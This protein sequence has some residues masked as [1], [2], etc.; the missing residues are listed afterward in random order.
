MPVDTMIGEEVEDFYTKLR[1]KI[2]NG[3]VDEAVMMVNGL[4]STQEK[5]GALQYLTITVFD[6][7]DRDSVLDRARALD[8]DS[9]LALALDSALDRKRA[10]AL[11]HALDLAL[12]FALAFA[13]DSARALASDRDH[14][15]AL[16]SGRALA[17]ARARV[18]LYASTIIRCLEGLVPKQL[19]SGDEYTEDEIQLAGHDPLTPITLVSQVAP[20][21]QALI[22][23]Q[24]VII[25][26][27]GEPFIE[28]RIRSISE[29][30]PLSFQ[31]DG[32]ADAIR[33][34]REIV[35]PW[36][37]KHAQ[38]M[39]ELE[40][41]EKQV[42][43]GKAEVDIQETR[44]RTA[45]TRAATKAAEKRQSAEIEQLLLENEAKRLQNEEK[46]LE[47]HREKLDLAL[48]IVERFAPDLSEKERLLAVTQMMES[49]TTLTESPLELLLPGTTSED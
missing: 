19:V 46:R 3:E 40:V 22:D 33:V 5:I 17:L 24:E 16:D 29:H 21:L 48:S 23:L 8:L 30:S 36:R 35:T 31:M 45:Q 26:L 2:E 32:V 47:I 18:Q 34:V 37:R 7:L 44:A 28:P 13:L 11:A 42:E 25:Q 1:E 9:A 14:A 38:Q 10:L 4:E 6:A 41:S 43:I 27:T 15:R 49:L 12:A 39:A 20:Y